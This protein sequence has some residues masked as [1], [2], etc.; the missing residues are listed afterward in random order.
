MTDRCASKRVSNPP[1]R[2]ISTPNS[3]QTSVINISSADSS[4]A[5]ST[6]SKRK[7]PSA[8]QTTV[9]DDDTEFKFPL[10]EPEGEDEED[11]SAEEEEEETQPIKRQKKKVEDEPEEEEEEEVPVKITVNLS[12]FSF[13]EFSKKKRTPK[14]S[15]IF[16]FMSDIPYYKFDRLALAKVNTKIP[17]TIHD[18]DDYTFEFHVPRKV[19]NYVELDADGYTHMISNTV[20]MPSPTVNLAAR[21]PKTAK[22]SE[23]DVDEEE[24]DDKKGKKKGKGKKS[25]PPSEKEISP[26]NTDI[27]SKIAVLREKYSCHANDGSDY[28][29]VSPDDQVHVPLG[30]PHFNMWAAAWAH[31][32]CDADKPPTHNIFARDNLKADCVAGVTTAPS[33]LQRRVAVSQAQTGSSAPV[34][35]NH[36]T[37]PDAL[38]T[39]LLPAPAAAPLPAPTPVPTP[40]DPT[41][42]ALLPPNTIISKGMLISEFCTEHNRGE[43]ILEKLAKNG[44]RKTDGFRFILLSHLTSI[45]FLQGEI[46]ELR[47]AMENWA[48]PKPV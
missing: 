34:I 40:T 44:Y 47:S 37:L 12:I 5:A 39:A 46:V 36:F 48:Q 25:K 29:W 3:S 42:E 14:S 15:S 30:N 43:S 23:D 38:I 32:T 21:L 11:E 16:T 6:R 35:N 41:H 8:P 9:A 45:D 7:I 26:I 27:N 10:D 1:K 19:T 31:G 24:D 20:P 33:I 17:R 2:F 28:C 22:E 18:D 4:P 13:T